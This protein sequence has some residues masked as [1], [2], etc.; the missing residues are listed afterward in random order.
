MHPLTRN[1][2]E[3]KGLRQLLVGAVFQAVTDL[4]PGHRVQVW[5]LKSHLVVRV[6]LSDW[7]WLLCGLWHLWIWWRVTRRVRRVQDELRLWPRK[8]EVKVWQRPKV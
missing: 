1:A 3:Q 7:F 4:V 8:V 5:A 2:L 6:W